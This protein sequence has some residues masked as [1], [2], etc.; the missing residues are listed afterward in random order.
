MRNPDAPTPGVFPGPE[1]MRPTIMGERYVVSA[2]HP[3]VA[4]AAAC[5]LERGG[6]AIDA[7]V[8]GGIAS[9][10]VQADMCNFGGVAPIL[11]RPAG[12]E[13]VWSISGVGGWG[14]EVTIEK[15]RERF[16]G[17]M[18]LGAPVA[19]VPAAPDAWV[20]AL[21]RFG[22]WSFSEAAK[23]AIE[24][25][26]DGFPLDYRTASSLGIL[27][28]GFG[29][30]AT[31]R[32]IYWPAGRPPEVGERLRQADLA[33]LLQDLSGA[34]E[35]SERREALENV[36]RAFYEGEVAAQI[37]GFMREHGGWLTEEDLATFRC[38]VSPAPSRAYAGHRVHATGPFS[39]GPVLLQALAI[40]EGLDLADTGHN[41]TDYTHYV[42]EALKLAFSDRERFYGDP[43]F[44]DVDLYHLLS[45]EY[46]AELRSLIR[47][48]EGLPDLP[49]VARSAPGRTDTTFLCVIDGEGNAFCATPSDTL[50][51]GPIV[52][53]LGVIV[54]PRGVQ[55]RLDPEHPNALGPGKRPCLTP[56]AA[57][58]LT[59][60][61]GADD[62]VTA[63]G[64][65]GG[66]VI[67]QAMLQAFLNRVHFGMTQQQAVEAPRVS[68]FAF[69]GSFFPNVH[70][71]G[72][73]MAESRIESEV[74]S[75]LAARGH[76][77]REWPAYEFDAGGVSVVGDLRPPTAGGGRVLTAGADPRRNCYALGR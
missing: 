63:F 43:G 61:E 39:Q 28:R 30:W 45:D 71:P 37:V 26:A 53:G 42:I 59:P 50:D 29:R 8:A 68:T 70:V 18:P 16:G 7:G 69:P 44:V 36:R 75:G 22:T 60:S 77:V 40:L 10:V 27:G 23:P 74:R 20:S 32:G 9:N 3:L 41:S 35:G 62:M 67:V 64:C 38:E 48:H 51:G 21:S 57:I 55:S 34:E 14:S 76:D 54:S 52:P 31:S 25:A 12:S 49:T 13:T 58:A 24:Y 11:V 65:P 47:R 15:F 56:C 2:G 4:R 1:S 73:V 6:N 19:V 33:R 5:V 72:L 46:A 66:D 17:D